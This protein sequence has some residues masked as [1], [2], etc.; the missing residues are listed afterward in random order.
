L[1]TYIPADWTS[2]RATQGAENTTLDIQKD[3]KG[4]FVIYDLKADGGTATL[5][6][7]N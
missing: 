6:E 7:G 5:K 3:E 2:A 4:N 1:K